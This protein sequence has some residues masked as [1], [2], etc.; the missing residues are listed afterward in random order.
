MAEN[1]I[2]KKHKIKY[3]YGEG[4]EIQ[5]VQNVIDYTDAVINIKLSDCYLTIKGEGFKVQLLN[6][7]SGELNVSG[8]II[9]FTYSKSREKQSLLKR[10]V[11]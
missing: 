10:F 2:I 6:V 3:I 4:L 5:G 9:S 7:D 8:R 1:S 11:K